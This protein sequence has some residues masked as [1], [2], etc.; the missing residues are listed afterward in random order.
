VA[1]VLVPLP[2]AVDDHQTHNARFLVERGAAVLIPQAEFT[3]EKLA[4]LL[5]GI[6]RDKLLVMA[7]AAHEAAKPDATQAVARVC[8]E[9]AHAA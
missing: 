1:S 9:L 3:P 5:Q 7:Q 2:S 4:Q 8:M 6:A